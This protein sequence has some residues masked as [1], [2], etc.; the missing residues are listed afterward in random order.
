MLGLIAGRVS[1]LDRATAAA[2]WLHTEAGSHWDADEEPEPAVDDPDIQDYL[3]NHDVLR[4][5]ADWYNK[6]IER[7][8]EGSIEH[9]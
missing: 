6:R 3:L 5:A 9:G 8:I 1:R 2:I 4:A 7:C